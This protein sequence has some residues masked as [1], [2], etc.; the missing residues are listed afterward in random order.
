MSGPGISEAG[1]IPAGLYSV[2]DD[3]TESWEIEPTTL[4]RATAHAQSLKKPGYR[5]PVVAGY[6][7]EY[8]PVFNLA[9]YARQTAR[10]AAQAA[11]EAADAIR[12]AV[13][14]ASIAAQVAAKPAPAKNSR[15][16]TL[17]LMLARNEA[18]LA[19]ELAKKKRDRAEVT[20]LQANCAKLRADLGIKTA[21][22][23]LL[24]AIFG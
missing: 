8:S 14:V 7:G 15:E 11:Q 1:R 22:E 18:S 10:A 24:T 20:R 16:K 17:W 23:V 3:Q 21:E 2:W 19:A 13:T 12:R 6:A 5:T 9:A 4:E